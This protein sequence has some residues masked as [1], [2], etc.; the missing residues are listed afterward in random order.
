MIVASDV[1][2]WSK[3]YRRVVNWSP[4]YIRYNLVPVTRIAFWRNRR[5]DGE[6][7]IA[8]RGRL[9]PEM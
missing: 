3:R 5:G 9:W 8:I 4:P 6:E 2:K 1:N 7:D